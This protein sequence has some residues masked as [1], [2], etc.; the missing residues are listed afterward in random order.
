MRILANAS[1]ELSRIKAGGGADSTET[2]APD[3][4][5]GLLSLAGVG[6]TSRGPPR[7]PLHIPRGSR[8]LSHTRPTGRANTS[9]AEAK[10]CQIRESCHAPGTSHAKTCRQSSWMEARK[11]AAPSS[12]FAFA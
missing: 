7:R 2:P 10:P 8:G 12:P 4:R 1:T 9:G 6:T 3:A 11:N 5:R